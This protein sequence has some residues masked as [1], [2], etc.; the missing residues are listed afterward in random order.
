MRLKITLFIILASLLVT[1][2]KKELKF[3]AAFEQGTY[4]AIGKSLQ[5]YPNAKIK[6]YAT[7]GSQQIIGDLVAGKA[8]LGIVQLDVLEELA[9]KN[10]KIREK[11]KILLPLYSEEM[12]LIT[13]KKIT[14]LNQATGKNLWIGPK[15]SGMEK[16]A[17]ILSKI[18]SVDTKKIKI[19][20]SDFRL[21]ANKLRKKALD[22][23]LYIAGKPVLWLK[24]FGKDFGNSYKLISLPE[25]VL[26]KLSQKQY[27]YHSSVI[28]A[29][30][31]PW[32]NYDA[33]TLA[34]RSVL[35]SN[36]NLCDRNVKG[37]IQF[38]TRKQDELKKA[39]QKWSEFNIKSAKIFLESKKALA[40]SKALQF[41]KAVE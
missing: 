15:G 33:Q 9:Q 13:K 19:D 29:N 20:Q 5:T 22:G 21:A 10:N 28:P 23:M 36:S 17:F 38:I 14:S 40:H 24:L 11:V 7:N 35:V 3:A 30:T 41:L 32:Q 16:T 27:A 26:K 34:V 39:H 37:L 12:H 1:C 8:D 31:Y 18:F 4:Y 25:K 6:T 2:S